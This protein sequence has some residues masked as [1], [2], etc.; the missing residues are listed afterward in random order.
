VAAA[1][2][3]H[4]DLEDPVMRATAASLPILLAAL[5]ACQRTPREASNAPGAIGTPAHGAVIPLTAGEKGWLDSLRFTLLKVDP[6]LV[7]SEHFALGSEDLPPRSAIPVHRHAKDEEL[8]IVYRGRAAI[9][10]A[11]SSYE[12]NAGGVVYIPRNTW[13]GVRNPG[14]DTLTVFFIFPTPHFLDYMRALTSPTPGGRSLSADEYARLNQ[15][16]GI[17]YRSP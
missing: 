13:V 4:L 10:L 7:G 14:P 15:A 5:A 2:H 8:L 9:A 16:G 6:K 1:H 12:A 17:E 11:D 3:E